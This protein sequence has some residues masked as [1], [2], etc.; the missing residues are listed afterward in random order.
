MS[1]IVNDHD[2]LHIPIL[3]VYSQLKIKIN[4]PILGLCALHFERNK[5]LDSLNK[6]NGRH[7]PDVEPKTI[8]AYFSGTINVW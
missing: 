8:R 1:T 3:S 5:R 7:E 6:L 4:K 2:C